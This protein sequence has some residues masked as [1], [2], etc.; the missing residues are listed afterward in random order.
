MV[1]VAS[2]RHA[3]RFDCGR[4]DVKNN[5]RGRGQERGCDPTLTRTTELRY[6][7]LLYSAP[8]P[9]VHAYNVSTWGLWNVLVL[10][11]LTVFKK[12]YSIFYLLLY[13]NYLSVEQN[14]INAILLQ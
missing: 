6:Y 11:S 4:D 3:H 8:I 13:N 10:C 9:H 12:S 1:V 2:S 7:Q 5:E 14:I